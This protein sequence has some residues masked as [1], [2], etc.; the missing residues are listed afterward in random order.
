MIIS[1]MQFAFIL[2]IVCVICAFAVSAGVGGGALY[3]P[4]YVWIVGDSHLA[5]PL[6]KITTNGVAW[7][8]FLFNVWKR[9]P[10]ADQP[11]I[12]YDVALMLEPLTL[13]G[14]IIGVI[15][16]LLMASWQILIV[17]SCVTSF[18][19]Y[20]T[21]KKGWQMKVEEDMARQLLHDEP[22]VLM[23][24]GRTELHELRQELM[25]NYTP[26]D[27][28]SE[29]MEEISSPPLMS[30]EETSA[31]INRIMGR[32]SRQYPYK[33]ILLLLLC[34]L[35]HGMT[36]YLIGGPEAGICG[37]FWKKAILVC[38]V[39]MQLTVTKLWRD[40]CL[41][42]QKEK[43][44]FGLCTSSFRFDR[45]NTIVFPF[46]SLC[47]G[48]CSGALGIAGGLIKGPIMIHWG[49]VPQSSTATA[50]FMILFTSTSTILQFLLL[51]R[52][53]WNA[54]IL[55]WITG[56][57]GGAIGTH[58]MRK[59][60]ERSGRQSYVSLFL[61]LIIVISGLCM[62]GVVIATMNGDVR[63]DMA[64]SMVEFC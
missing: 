63:T 13:L 14:T 4:F 39:L 22:L 9:H 28:A 46:L 38:N 36:L 58:V 33:K 25:L 21:F 55:L 62:A 10:S 19:A 30:L 26:A 11:L 5:V 8:A 41:Q 29:N 42:R 43:D 51:G 17:L 23:K 20:K 49:L 59:M 56:F 35:W 27:S 44:R 37:P 34:M 24:D 60:L 32:D 47:A 61:A 48:V 7:S 18:T 50:I 57:I 40:K 2:P 12:N 6:A 45:N 1:A 16:N 31:T 54:G 15:A 64:I 3:M 52:I 53:D